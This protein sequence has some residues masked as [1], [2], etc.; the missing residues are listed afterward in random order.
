MKEEWREHEIGLKVSNLGRVFIP[1]SG[2]NKEHYTYGF[3]NGT[4]YLRVKKNYKPYL[5]H[6]LVAECFIPNPNNY[7]IINHKN[8]NTKDNRVE[9]IEWC[10]YP[11][12]NNYGNR[13]KKAISKVSKS[14]LQYDL[15]GNFIREWPSI[16]EIERQLGFLRTSICQCCKCK[17]HHKTAYGFIWRYK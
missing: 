3:D 12:N 17:P 15:N 2:S 10:D 9:N 7:P 6:R 8:E 1:K 16:V 14:V 13:T 11:Y 5:V 4:G